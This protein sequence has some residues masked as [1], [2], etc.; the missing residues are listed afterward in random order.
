MAGPRDGVKSRFIERITR[1]P[2]AGE[3]SA[4]GSSDDPLAGN[5]LTTGPTL[6][7]SCIL[8]V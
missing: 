6:R 2:G 4:I 1:R 7:A 8:T 3:A 5:R